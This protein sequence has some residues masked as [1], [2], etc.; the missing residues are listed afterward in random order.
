M[1][2][3]G[4]FY[5]ELQD[6]SYNDAV[7]QEALRFLES[8]EFDSDNFWAEYLDESLTVDYEIFIDYNDYNGSS[9][10]LFVSMCKA[11]SSALP[12]VNFNAVSHF[13]NESV[14]FNE[15]FV[16]RYDDN[17]L[18]VYRLEYLESN[19]YDAMQCPDCGGRIYLELWDGA[20]NN[21]IPTEAYCSDCDK[22]IPIKDIAEITEYEI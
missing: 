22:C 7:Y 2:Q 8:A 14:G 16:V 18:T 19:D 3:C 17:L 5:I 4:G 12:H 6:A 9:E 21:I 13:C 1:R 15:D 20:L 10:P 11:I